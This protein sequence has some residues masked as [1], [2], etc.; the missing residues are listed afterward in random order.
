MYL[1]HSNFEIKQN[2]KMKI[3]NGK[4]I[5]LVLVFICKKRRYGDNQGLSL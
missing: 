4:S 5:N 2:H 3:F 1:R